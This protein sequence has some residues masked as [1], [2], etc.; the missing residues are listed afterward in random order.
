MPKSRN[1]LKH[2]TVEQAARR[3]D[4]GA[5]RGMHHISKGELCIVVRGAMRNDKRSYCFACGTAILDRAALELQQL[6]DQLGQPTP[7][8]SASGG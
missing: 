3:R 1:V 4:C 8:E 2:V 5:S 7:A 6:R